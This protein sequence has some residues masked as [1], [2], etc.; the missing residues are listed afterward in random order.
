MYKQF[1]YYSY[2]TNKYGVDA[3]TTMLK[4]EAR[5]M[6]IPYPLQS[7]WV[8]RY[9]IWLNRTLEQDEIESFL[10]DL[11]RA[12]KAIKDTSEPAQRQRLN[13]IQTGIDFI[14]GRNFTPVNHQNK[15][16]IQDLIRE[17]IESGGKI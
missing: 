11:I 6:G 4:V 8:E 13:S 5:C 7:G 10:A 16:Q 2:L 9:G 3:P 15:K 14:L 17:E 12:K 1:S